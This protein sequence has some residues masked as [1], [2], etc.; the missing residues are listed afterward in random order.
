MN[1][2]KANECL[3]IADQNDFGSLCTQ[4][5]RFLI[6][7]ETNNEDELV[8]LLEKPSSGKDFDYADYLEIMADAAHKVCFYVFFVFY[9][10]INDL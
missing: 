1:L 6:A 3:Q 9:L 8:Q 10:L 4:Y 7:L 2:P 5:I